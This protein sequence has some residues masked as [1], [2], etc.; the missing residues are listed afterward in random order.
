MHAL[1]KPNPIS[2]GD[3]GVGSGTG[4]L[5]PCPVVHPFHVMVWAPLLLPGW[6]W[7]LRGTHPVP[8][9]SPV[10]LGAPRGTVLSSRCGRLAVPAVTRTSMEPLTWPQ[11][12]ATE[13]PAVRVCLQG[14]PAALLQLYRDPHCPMAGSCGSPQHPAPP[15]APLRGLSSAA[16]T[17]ALSV[18]S[19]VWKGSTLCVTLVTRPEAFAFRYLPKSV[20]AGCGGSGGPKGSAFPYSLPPTPPPPFRHVAAVC[21]QPWCSPSSPEG[22]SKSAQSLACPRSPTGGRHHGRHPASFA[23]RGT[24]R[25][26]AKE[27]SHWEV[28]LS[29]RLDIGNAVPA[30]QP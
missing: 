23:L 24:P 30:L 8:V 26:A 12:G 20:T 15:R 16:V 11:C 4:P 27:V 5:S 22:S 6:R 14:V 19:R 21:R 9:S 25:S 28:S 18:P 10:C 1:D 17:E 2:R 13:P 3:A 7:E 29:S